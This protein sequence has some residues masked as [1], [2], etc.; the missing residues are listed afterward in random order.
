MRS[1]ISRGEEAESHGPNTM[2]KKTEKEH[3][4]DDTRRKRFYEAPLNPMIIASTVNT[5]GLIQ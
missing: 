5:N 2:Q 3:R 1:Y 4:L